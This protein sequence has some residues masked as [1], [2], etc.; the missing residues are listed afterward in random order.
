MVYRAHDE[1]LDRDVALRVLSPGTVVEE[2]TG[3]LSLDVMLASG[4]LSERETINLGSQL[5]EGLRATSSCIF[6]STIRSRR[7][8]VP[9]LN[10]YTS[11]LVHREKSNSLHLM[12]VFCTSTIPSC[13]ALTTKSCSRTSSLR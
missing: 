6:D 1:R 9:V 5:A 7:Q 4:P 2:F 3:G 10:R 12:T 13:L 8:R 11:M